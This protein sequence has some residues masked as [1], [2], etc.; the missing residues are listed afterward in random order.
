MGRTLVNRRYLTVLSIAIVVSLASWPGVALAEGTDLESAAGDTVEATEQVAAGGAE[1]A[2]GAASD[3]TEAVVRATQDADAAGEAT[4]Q[5]T[6]TVTGTTQ[7]ISSA[8]RPLSEEVA[9]AA[10]D[11]A[12]VVTGTVDASGG[13]T[14]TVDT[15]VQTSGT[16]DAAVLTVQGF[17]SEIV[18]ASEEAVG[19]AGGTNYMASDGGVFVTDVSTFATAPTPESDGTANVVLSTAD[20]W[21]RQI[22]AEILAVRY[23]GASVVVAC[24]R[25][26]D[27]NP[28]G[29]QGIL[30]QD[31]SFTEEVISTIRSLAVTGLN[32]LLKMWSILVLGLLGAVMIEVSRRRRPLELWE[33][34]RS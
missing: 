4:Q 30:G 16:T 14:G 26:C 27:R 34:S 12:G 28:V 9:G 32:L 8:A 21:S 10:S 6:D 31:Y 7:Q 33:P 5:V 23:A 11:A 3:G 1:V 18:G 19:A 29:V 20:M 17:R 15:A 2:G 25:A 22:A 24:T 13:V